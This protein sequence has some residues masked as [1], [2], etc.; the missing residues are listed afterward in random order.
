M[1]GMTIGKAAAAAGVGVETVRFY[2]RRG[3]IARPPR[4]VDG[5]FRLYSDDTVRRVRFVREARELG[6]SLREAAELLQLRDAAA[7][8][9]DVRDR[10][11]AKLD[12]VDDKITRL[13]AIRHALAGL[14]ERCP[15]AGS[16]DGCSIMAALE[17]EDHAR[18]DDADKENDG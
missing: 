16:L 2:E 15:G 5:G 3:L 4:P 9:A 17:G 6:F 11:R 12:D 14:V 10:A 7:D 13:Q 8:A 18:T 1:A